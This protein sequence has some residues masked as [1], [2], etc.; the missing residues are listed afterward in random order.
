MTRSGS[1]KCQQVG[2]GPNEQ[3]VDEPSIDEPCID[4]STKQ[5][6]DEVKEVGDETCLLVMPVWRSH[7]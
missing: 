5:I 3:V 4:E 1:I 7:D 6:V 2:D